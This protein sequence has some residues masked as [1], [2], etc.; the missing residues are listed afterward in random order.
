M[1]WIGFWLS[2]R[3]VDLADPPSGTP[4]DSAYVVSC[5]DWPQ[6]EELGARQVADSGYSSYALWVLPGQEQDELEEAG[7]LVP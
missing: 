7:L 2:P 5:A 6:A 3:D 1:N 4:F